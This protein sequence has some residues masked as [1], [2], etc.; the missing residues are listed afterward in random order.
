MFL[1]YLMD[2]ILASV[3]AHVA[4]HIVK[5]CLLKLLAKKTR[6]IV[7]R[8][9]SLMFHANQVCKYSKLYFQN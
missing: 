7:T 9:T 4:K 5:H 2:D 1:V 8:N 6:I 3:D